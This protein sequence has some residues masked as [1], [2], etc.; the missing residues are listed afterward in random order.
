MAP[1]ASSD[2]TKPTP[3]SSSSPRSRGVENPFIAFKRL[4]DSQIASL[5][6]SVTNLPNLST[7]SN[8][9]HRSRILDEE[10][11]RTMKE[12]DQRLQ[13]NEETE[14][15]RDDTRMGLS[16]RLKSMP[17][18]YKN[19]TENSRKDAQARNTLPG[20]DSCRDRAGRPLQR[21]TAESARKKG[22]WNGIGLGWDGRLHVQKELREKSHHMPGAP[23]DDVEDGGPFSGSKTAIEWLMNDPY[24]PVHL[25]KDARC[26]SPRADWILAFEDLLMLQRCGFMM[27][28]SSD[29]ITGQSPKLW[30]TSLISGGLLGEAWGLK[31]HATADTSMWLLHSSGIRYDFKLDMNPYRFHT[32]CDALDT[33]TGQLRHVRPMWQAGDD[34]PVHQLLASEEVKD[35]SLQNDSEDQDDD[36]EQ[37]ETNQYLYLDEDQGDDVENEEE[38]DDGVRDT[39][40]AGFVG[41]SSPLLHFNVRCDGHRCPNGGHYASIRGDRYH[42][43][44]CYD[45][46]F[47][48]DCVNTHPPNHD[49]EIID[50]LFSLHASLTNL[51]KGLRNSG[52]EAND[53]ILSWVDELDERYG[54]QRVMERLVGEDQSLLETVFW[55]ASDDNTTRDEYLKLDKLCSRLKGLFEEVVGGQTVTPASMTMPPPAHLESEA[56][57]QPSSE[58]DLYEALFFPTSKRGEF[59]Y[60]FYCDG[61]RCLNR[62]SSSFIRGQRYHCD[63]CDNVDFCSD[64]V[65]SHS[66]SGHSVELVHPSTA[67]YDSLRNLFDNV[68]YRD[69][70]GHSV[71]LDIATELWRHH[72]FKGA[73]QVL[74]SGD[75]ESL[76]KAED[77]SGDYEDQLTKALLVGR[78]YQRMRQTGIL[79]TNDDN[80][81]IEDLS[82]DDMIETIARRLNP[83]DISSSRQFLKDLVKTLELSD[84]PNPDP[85]L[86]SVATAAPEAHQEEEPVSPTKKSLKAPSSSIQDEAA[87]T[88]PVSILST[89]TTTEKR[90]LA[91][92]SVQTKIVLK[93]RFSDGSEESRE[94]VHHTNAQTGERHSVKASMEDESQRSR[95]TKAGWFWR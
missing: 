37:E 59:H 61:D 65:S 46:D 77:D 43:K 12:R 54:S 57:E 90:T 3:P 84:R 70:F 45:T 74:F 67:L 47:C 36:D 85:V 22:W 30:I 92:G 4:A 28:N 50:P 13:M 72:G 10:L 55:N 27:S 64:C 20:G 53:S 33:R 5:L 24:S 86:L 89:L 38:E 40:L 91:D 56:A 1:D 25:E 51:V 88:Q 60:G 94:T 52:F 80:D 6:Q 42:C 15:L 18:D 2:D 14:R 9:R 17:E 79:S 39:P 49:I 58:G 35:S 32:F 26:S 75:I 78:V 82:M 23:L 93:K 34:E 19:A 31:K 95:R 48:S 29:R 66:P 11:E 44:Q 81:G 21:E 62:K 76:E 69:K 68:G 16:E 63:H 7:P 73:N 71:L 41:E 87:N 8:E 83:Y